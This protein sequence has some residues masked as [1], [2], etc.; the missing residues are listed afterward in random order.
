M[1]HRPW[2]LPSLLIGLSLLP[3]TALLGADGP[4]AAACAG[5]AS[6]AERLACY[7]ALFPPNSDAAEPTSLESPLWQLAARQER[8][9]EQA[10]AGLRVVEDADRV[11]LTAPALGTPPPRPTL[12]LACHNEITHFEIHLPEPAGVGRVDLTLRLG[13]ARLRQTWRLRDGGRVLSGGRGLPAIETLRELLAGGTLSLQSN[14]SHDLDG[15]RFDLNGLGE[16]LQPLRAQC[17]W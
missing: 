7:D 12:V 5:V 4:S 2:M 10:D 6:R 16:A 3:V 1:S 11:L 9:R 17:R 13:E 15:L 14:E 8:G